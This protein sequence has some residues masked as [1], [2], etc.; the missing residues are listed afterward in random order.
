MQVRPICRAR[1]AESRSVQDVDDIRT[2]TSS[3]AAKLAAAIDETAI[4]AVR[5]YTPPMIMLRAEF[6]R[7]IRDVRRR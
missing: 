2:L 6:L 1:P 5:L 7:G 3:Q 4:G